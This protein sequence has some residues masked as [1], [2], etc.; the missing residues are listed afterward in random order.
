MHVRRYS[1]RRFTHLWDA[2]K[3]R[4]GRCSAGAGQAVAASCEA[5]RAVLSGRREARKRGRRECVISATQPGIGRCAGAEL[6]DCH[7]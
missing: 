3:S 7:G 2:L 6:Q 1:A 4:G 5:C